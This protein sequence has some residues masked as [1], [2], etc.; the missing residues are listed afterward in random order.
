MAVEDRKRR[1]ARYRPAIAVEGLESRALLSSFPSAGMH[2]VHTLPSA[3][4]SSAERA[5]GAAVDLG[6]PTANE[7][8]KQ[9]FTAR[10]TG[11]FVTTTGRFQNQPLQGEIV[12]AGGSNQSLRINSQMQFFLYR[13]PTVAPNGQIALTPKNVSSTGNLLLLD[14]TAD[15]NSLVHGILPA[16][17]TWTVNGGSAGLWQGAT[18]TGTLDV[19]FRLNKAPHGVHSMGKAQIAVKGLIQT[20]HGLTLDTATA[21]NRARQ[22]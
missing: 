11:S 17:Y 16:H 1:G 6:A 21:G 10:L 15:P 4:I 19:G 7:L 22:P 2:H 9:R 3:A 12:A 14:L 20:N 5:L 13:D 8:A 18:G